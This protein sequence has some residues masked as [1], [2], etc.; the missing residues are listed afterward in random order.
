M[1]QL[2]LRDGACLAYREA[3]SGPAIV[4]LHGWSMRSEV[5]AAQFEALA[6]RFRLV[7][8][9]LRGHG[10]SSAAAEGDD[11]ATLAGDVAEL[12]QALELDQLILVGW[13]MGATVAWKLL[14]SEAAARIRGIV[15]I[16]MVPRILS[17]PGWPYGLKDGADASVYDEDLARMRRN[18]PAFTREY[19]PRNVARGRKNKRSQ[20]LADLFALVREND[21]ESMALLWRSLA[22]EDLRQFVAELRIPTLIA[23]GE[24]GQL[25]SND[26][27]AWMSEHISNS[28]RVGFS[29]SGHSPHMEE[30]AKF[31]AVLE[32]FA[33]E[34]AGEAATARVNGTDI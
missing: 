8:P 18:W 32:Q 24:R 11:L 15:V 23:H 22:D 7:A 30:S 2:Q 29:D 34:L 21:A 26:A 33:D 4:L 19:I 10:D 6:P 5:F 20:L 17:E 25:Y 9:E 13:S 3:G 1:R 31:N 12:V 27:F 28:R 16:D 14:Q